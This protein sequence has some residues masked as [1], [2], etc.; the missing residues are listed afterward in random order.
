LAKVRRSS[1]CELISYAAYFI[2]T[3][4]SV[5]GQNNRQQTNAKSSRER[6][7][8]HYVRNNLRISLILTDI[9]LLWK[10]IDQST[11]TSTSE[12]SSKPFEITNEDKQ[13]NLNQ[14]NVVE[15]STIKELILAPHES[16]KLRL[17]FKALRAH[18]HLHILGVKYR[19]GLTSF[20][21]D[22][23]N[24]SVDFNTLYGKHLFE[25][26]GTRLNNNPQAMRSVVYDTDNRLNF[27]IVNKTARLQ[28][29]M[30]SL[31]KT[32]I[33][34]QFERVRIYFINLSNEFP[35]GNIK[36]A[37][38]ELQTCR[39][40][41]SDTNKIGDELKID[42]DSLF[43][44]EKSSFEFKK[45]ILNQ[46][47]QQH[48]PFQANTNSNDF[49]SQG[50]NNNIYSLDNVILKPNEHYALDMWIRA[51]DIEGD[52]KFYFMFFYEDFNAN[53]GHQPHAKPSPKR[54]SASAHSLK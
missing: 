15:C 40:Y 16:Y 36:I 11:T 3:A 37:S 23:N 8:I 27:K 29:E 4:T 49:S 34:N 52:Y 44:F 53:I 32:M 24:T 30:D 22:S 45:E 41:F 17:N 6:I 13:E 12:E 14:Q 38:N 43:T 50:Y 20:S 1:L 7:S 33:C 51:P 42:Q 31:P 26:R 25:L 47:Q 9:T 10:F 19:L 48:Q 35:I 46:E 21:S 18:G 5:P 28:I 39:L 54:N 2:Q